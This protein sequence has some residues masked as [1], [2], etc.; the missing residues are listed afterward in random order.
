MPSY[1]VLIASRKSGKLVRPSIRVGQ[2]LA[3]TDGN[4]A[5]CR[6]CGKWFDAVTVSAECGA[7]CHRCELLVSG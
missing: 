3:T 5:L 1:P 6:I 2:L 7:I 4:V